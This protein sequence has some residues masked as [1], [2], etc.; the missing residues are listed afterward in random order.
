VTLL[1]NGPLPQELT[2]IKDKAQFRLYYENTAEYPGSSLTDFPVQINRMPLLAYCRREGC[3]P[4][5]SPYIDGQGDVYT[6]SLEGAAHLGNIDSGAQTIEAQRQQMRRDRT[7]ACKFGVNP[8]QPAK[9][10]D[11]DNFL[12]GCKDALMREG[13]ADF[14]CP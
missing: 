13:I 2:L 4:T 12:Q 9:R 10:S 5:A 3:A 14:T 7:G 6:C 8:G 1:A 11:L